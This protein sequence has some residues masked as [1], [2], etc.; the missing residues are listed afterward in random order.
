[1]DSSSVDVVSC[2]TAASKASR[3][4]ERRLRAEADSEVEETGLVKL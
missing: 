2:S 3:T 1:M 4:L